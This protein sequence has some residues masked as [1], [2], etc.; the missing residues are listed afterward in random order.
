MKFDGLS[1]DCPASK[2]AADLFAEVKSLGEESAE[3]K[4]VRDRALKY[5]KKKKYLANAYIVDAPDY[6]WT[7]T[8]L[9]PD[10]IKDRYNITNTGDIVDILDQI[11]KKI[12]AFRNNETDYD[13]VYKRV[14]KDLQDG[15]LGKVTFDDIK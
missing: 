7:E 8:G 15:Y 6:F 9:D 10:N 1:K 13:R 12:G 3:G 5:Y 11:G 2:I 14:I 4:E